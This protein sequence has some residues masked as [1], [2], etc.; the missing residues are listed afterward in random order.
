MNCDDC[1]AQLAAF[2]DGE[3]DDSP[4]SAVEAHLAECEHCMA[5][6][7]ELARTSHL[8][9]EALV[10]H[11]APDILRARIANALARE[12]SAGSPLPS[13]HR[14]SALAAAGLTIALLSSGG[15]FALMQSHART[16]ATADAVLASHVR[17]LMP[18]H[19]IDVASTDQ[20][21]VK[22][23]FNG[24]VDFSPRVPALDSIGFSLVGGRLDY[25]ADRAVTAVVYKRRQHVINVYAWP[26]TGV[27]A[28]PTTSG[29]H[30]YNLV[31]WRLDGFDYWAASDLN[32]TELSQFVAAFSGRRE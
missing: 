13:R 3:L 19:L 27:D 17:S 9:Q 18:G 2:H 20:H 8:L 24:R 4:C 25:V 22:P 31:R 12:R 26:A 14:W 28:A 10:H 15:T 23:W 6:R 1:I 32:S 5:R 29:S 21:N 16:A 11:A 7:D 30:G